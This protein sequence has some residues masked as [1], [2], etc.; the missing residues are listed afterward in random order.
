[1][2]KVCWYVKGCFEYGGVG[3]CVE[4][5]GTERNF[6]CKGGFVES[7]QCAGKE[8]DLLRKGEVGECVQCVGTKRMCC[9]GG[10]LLN[11]YSVLVRK[12]MC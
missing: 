4:G 7:L 1:M 5:A 6:L 3:E 11:V 9:V 2:C 12:L 10:D 8:I